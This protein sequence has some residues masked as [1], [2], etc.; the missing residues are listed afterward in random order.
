MFG[1][2]PKI[3]QNWYDICLNIVNKET[4]AK[5]LYCESIN[6]FSI[7]EILNTNVGGYNPDLFSFENW[8]IILVGPVTQKDVDEFN[9]KCESLAVTL[10]NDRWILD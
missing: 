6:A 10:K 8:T 1:R 9:A 3:G 7:E 5:N 2:E 4:G